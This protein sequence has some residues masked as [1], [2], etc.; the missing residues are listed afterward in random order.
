MVQPTLFR[1]LAEDI[2]RF[3]GEGYGVDDDNDPDPENIL[4][5]TAPVSSSE[6]GIQGVKFAVDV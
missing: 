2:A 6:G 1:E 5:A 4:T 3:R